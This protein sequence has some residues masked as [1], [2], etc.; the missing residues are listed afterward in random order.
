MDIL[1]VD[2][3]LFVKGIQCLLSD[4]LLYLGRISLPAVVHVVVVD[5]PPE[6]ALA[7]IM[8]MNTEV[9]LHQALVEMGCMLSLVNLPIQIH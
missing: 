2:G 1:I 5:A 7:T 4:A 6:E 3:Y 9:Y 8:F